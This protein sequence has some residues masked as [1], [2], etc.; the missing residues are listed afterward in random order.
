MRLRALNTPLQWGP[1]VNASARPCPEILPRDTAFLPNST[2]TP[3][4]DS[5]W[6]PKPSPQAPLCSQGP[7]TSTFLEA[8]K[9]QGDFEISL[10]SHGP[11]WMLTASRAAS[12]THLS[13]HPSSPIHPPSTLLHP[14][15]HTCGLEV[16]CKKRK[17]HPGR[18]LLQPARSGAVWSTGWDWQGQPGPL[19]TGTW[20]IRMKQK[21]GR[22]DEE[23]KTAF[24]SRRA[25]FNS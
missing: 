20:K 3:N 24:G 7:F 4:A 21:E 15:T 6:S 19:E 22:R 11:R 17:V 10:P 13:I 12:P 2:R 5:C 14:S 23:R 1:F 9:A 8:N 18:L 25:R 16:A